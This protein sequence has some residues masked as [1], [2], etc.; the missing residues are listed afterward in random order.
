ML[1]VQSA[2]D[3]DV[4]LDID[5][6]QE[7]RKEEV[8]VGDESFGAHG[9]GE[10]RERGDD[11]RGDR[12]RLVDDRRV[13][14]NNVLCQPVGVGYEDLWRDRASCRLVSSSSE[15]RRRRT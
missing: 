9:T 1:A 10:V 15:R 13:S 6:L 2:A 12:V 3:A 8:E 4:G 7:D 5:A 11:G 14:C